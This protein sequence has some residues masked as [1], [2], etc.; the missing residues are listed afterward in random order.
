LL[1]AFRY[2]AGAAVVSFLPPVLQED[3]QGAQ[4]SHLSAITLGPVQGG[5]TVTVMQISSSD[6]SQSR[7]FVTISG[8]D[9]WNRLD[10]LNSLR[11]ALQSAA[12]N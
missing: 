2:L 8:T 12:D 6:R 4:V 10:R 5:P 3:L 9:G 11:F 7:L 1:R